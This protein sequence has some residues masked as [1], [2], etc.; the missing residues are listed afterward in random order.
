VHC[1]DSFFF[2]LIDR[3]AVR[4]GMKL[5][6]IIIRRWGLKEKRKPVSIGSCAYIPQNSLSVHLFN[7]TTV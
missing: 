7:V 1:E 4:N 3:Q 6:T 2:L 5:E